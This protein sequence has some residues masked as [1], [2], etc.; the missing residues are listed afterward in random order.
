[1]TTCI[2]SGRFPETEFKSY[3]NH[4]AYADIF[5]YSYVHCNWP[6]YLKNNYFNKII[7]I[8]TYLDFFDNIIWIDDDAFFFDFEKDIMDYAPKNNSFISLC[9]SPSHK[10]LK[11]VFSSGQFILKSNELS[12]R[13]LKDVLNTNLNLVRDWWKDELGYFSNGDQ[14]CMLYLLLENENYKSRM[15]L[16]DYKCFNSRWENVF[17][18]D[19]HKP[20]IL[21]F[22][23]RGKTKQ[24]NYIKA[25]NSLNLHPSLVSNTILK[26]YN[27]KVYDNYKVECEEVFK[28][29]FLSKLI[30]KISKWLKDL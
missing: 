12:K 30:R 26:S 22:T 5:G 6:T 7:Y 28:K 17:S 4:K 8:L 11:T 21:H 27:I 24:R 15:D 16:Y 19:V 29:T 20:L 13:F 14:D 2:I 23:G 10:E 1:M 3:I 9:K 18:V 25:Q